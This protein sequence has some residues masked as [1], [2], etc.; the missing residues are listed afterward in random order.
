MLIYSNIL[1][2]KNWDFLAQ[3]PTRKMITA[4]WSK[5]IGRMLKSL[6]AI[7]DTT[8]SKVKINKKLKPNTVSFF[9]AQPIPVLVS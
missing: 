7:T 2:N 9:I 8:A 3:D 6:W 5:K 4:S 1:N